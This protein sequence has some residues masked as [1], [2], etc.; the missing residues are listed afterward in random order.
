MTQH[1]KRR[2]RRFWRMPSADLEPMSN[3]L[4]RDIGMADLPPRMPPVFPH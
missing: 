2:W 4:R 1:A 3:H